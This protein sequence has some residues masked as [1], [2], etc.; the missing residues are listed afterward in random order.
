[1]ICFRLYI[2]TVKKFASKKR[3]GVMPLAE[4]LYLRFTASYFVPAI[5]FQNRVVGAFDLVICKEGHEMTSRRPC[6]CPDPILRELNSIIMQMLSL[7]F[8]EKYGCWS[9]EWQPRICDIPLKTDL[10]LT[11]SKWKEAAKNSQHQHICRLHCVF[12]SRTLEKVLIRMLI[13]AIPMDFSGKVQLWRS[14][15]ETTE[16][17]EFL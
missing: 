14:A 9:R 10:L 2:T 13:S 7:V 4:G 15:F 8:V 3:T 17:R 1:M 16:T 6:W 5:S 12:L 11:N